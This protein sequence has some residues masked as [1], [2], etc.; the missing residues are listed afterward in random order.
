MDVLRRSRD[1]S[2][3]SLED[4]SMHSSYEKI[5]EDRAKRMEEIISE[6]TARRPVFMR[7]RLKSLGEKEL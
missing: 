1:N 2:I 7:E 6:R 4:R 3:A 5:E